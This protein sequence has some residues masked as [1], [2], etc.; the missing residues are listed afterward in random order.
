LLF[1]QIFRPEAPTL[2]IKGGSVCAFPK[3]RACELPLY[4][5][6]PY[7]YRYTVSRRQCIPPSPHQSMPFTSTPTPSTQCVRTHLSW[8]PWS[9]VSGINYLLIPYPPA[10][11]V[12]ISPGG[13]CAPICLSAALFIYY[14]ILASRT[15][16]DDARG[17]FAAPCSYQRLTS[18]SSLLFSIYGHI[19]PKTPCYILITP[20]PLD[21]KAAVHCHSNPPLFFLS[22]IIQ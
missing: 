19:R 6:V 7:Y 4:I 17:Y 16:P 8:H 18:R 10:T 12:L 14:S 20:V 11:S 5:T 15:R 13:R 21:P 2:K 3:P 1:E 22:T 9:H